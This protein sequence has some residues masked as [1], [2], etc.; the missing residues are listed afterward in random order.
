MAERT[1]VHKQA[2]EQ[3]IVAAQIAE[4]TGEHALLQ[5]GQLCALVVV[6]AALAAGAWTAQTGHEIAAGILGTTGIA[7]VVT[8]FLADRRNEQRRAEEQAR[9]TEEEKRRRAAQA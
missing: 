5:R 1:L 8:A 6:L 7:G 2:M 3:Q 4:A 9:T